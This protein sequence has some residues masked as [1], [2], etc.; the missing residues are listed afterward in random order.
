MLQF[1]K[2]ISIDLQTDSMMMTA[3]K[4]FIQ[5]L[6]CLDPLKMGQ[7]RITRIRNGLD[8]YFNVWTISRPGE[9]PVGGFVVG[10]ILIGEILTHGGF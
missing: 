6:H 10:G 8:A 3:V 4:S 9:F 2:S 7:N 1:L 5:A